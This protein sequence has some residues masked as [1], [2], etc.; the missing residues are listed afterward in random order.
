MV[1]VGYGQISLKREDRRFMGPSAEVINER[2]RWA[3]RESPTAAATRNPH[4][5]LHW[6]KSVG[7]GGH[8]YGPGLEDIVNFPR[9]STSVLKVLDRGTSDRDL[10][11]WRG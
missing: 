2:S 10:E 8:K 5:V 7:D 3:G 6:M 1:R 4:C 11:A 9:K